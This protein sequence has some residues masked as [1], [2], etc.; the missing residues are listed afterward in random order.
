MTDNN[1]DNIKEAGDSIGCAAVQE[2]ESSSLAYLITAMTANAMAIH[3]GIGSMH[4]TDIHDLTA[5]INKLAD[6][7]DRMKFRER[8][9][10]AGK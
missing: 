7:Y 1:F 8:K 10:G 2:M 5:S 4:S 9:G 6:V 3:E